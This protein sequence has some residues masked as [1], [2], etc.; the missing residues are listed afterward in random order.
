V[1]EE[2]IP[3]VAAENLAR[4]CDVF[5]E[6]GVFDVE[7]SRAICRA[8]AAAGMRIRIHADEFAP[9][10]AA[11][12][13]AELGADS[14]DHLLA[15]SEAGLAKM[16]RRGLVAVLLP[17]TSY[18]LGLVRHAPARKMIEMGIPVALGTDCNPGSSMTESMPA[19]ISLA[20]TQLRMT[21]EE[22]WVAA[23][24]NAAC[25]LRLGKDRGRIAPGYRGDLV[26]FD[27]PTYEY[28]PYHF[29]VNHVAAVVVSGKVVAERPHSSNGKA[30]K[31]I[32]GGRAAPRGSGTSRRA[33]ASASR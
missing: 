13:A 25:S 7:E 33:A 10:G 29:G 6:R 19:V 22:C 1:I 31:R 24:R 32:S 2:Q 4:Y 26:V 11:D 3:A 5:C 23:T 15:A 12:L 28:L 20:V 17:G 16:A 21:A 30:S 27:M 8:A 9:S 18:S 14:A